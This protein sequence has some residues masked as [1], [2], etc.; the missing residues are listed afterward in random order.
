MIFLK[1]FYI[2]TDGISIGKSLVTKKYYYRRVCSVSKSVSNNIFLLPTDLP[3]DKKLP[4]KDSPT[5]IFVSDFVGKLIT[6]G[7]CVLRRRKNSVGKT[8]KSCSVG[9]SIKADWV[10]HFWGFV[11]AIPSSSSWNVPTWSLWTTK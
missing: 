8:V 5:E 7:I 1:F 4:M 10:D 2:I 6:D 11:G 3:T 9:I